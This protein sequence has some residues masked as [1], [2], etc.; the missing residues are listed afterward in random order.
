MSLKKEVIY[1]AVLFDVYRGFGFPGAE[2][3]GNFDLDFLL[4][5]PLIV[6]YLVS[7]QL[8]VIFLLI[9]M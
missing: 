7:N 9:L 4:F 6:K 1:N 2:D 8:A 3:L 5:H